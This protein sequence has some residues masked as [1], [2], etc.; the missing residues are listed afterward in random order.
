MKERQT[1]EAEGFAQAILTKAQAQAQAINLIADAMKDGEGKM[2]VQAQIAEKYVEMYGEMG[3]KSNTMVFSDK[4]GDVNAL[5][6][7]AAAVLGNT[8][9]GLDLNEKDKA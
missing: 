5:M 2:A 4:P 3:S 7:Q 8:F 6:A 9:K 1:L